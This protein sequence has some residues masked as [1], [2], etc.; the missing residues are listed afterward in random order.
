MIYQA[1]SICQVSE[2]FSTK[3]SPDRITAT[4]KT[5]GACI[6]RLH[7]RPYGPVHFI[8]SIC[9]PALL[10]VSRYPLAPLLVTQEPHPQEFPPKQQES[11]RNNL[12]VCPWDVYSVACLDESCA[13]PSSSSA[14]TYHFQ[15]GSYIDRVNNTESSFTITGGPKRGLC[16][17]PTLPT[18]STGMLLP[19]FTVVSLPPVINASR[20]V[21]YVDATVRQRQTC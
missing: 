15:W 19:T 12:D 2:L 9:Q 20:Q 8:S 7:S 21:Q 4:Q 14:S 3:G 16:M 17:N 1:S 6:S 10:P 11:R 13:V 5:G 18:P